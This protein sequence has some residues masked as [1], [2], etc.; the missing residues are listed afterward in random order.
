[1]L[2][3]VA[4]HSPHPEAEVRL[5]M[6]MLTLRA[7]RAG[8]G[9]VTGQDL[10]GWLQDDAERV[11]GRLVTGG[12]LRLPGTVAEVMASRPEDPVEVTVPTLLPEQPRPFTFGK[13]TRA[14][15]SGWAQKVVGDRKLRKRN[16]APPPGSWPCTPP[17]RRTPPRRPARTGQAGP[18]RDDLNSSCRQGGCRSGGE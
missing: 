4:A 13:T 7:A 2:D 8:T 9:N 10:T 6:L 1:M 12:W 15:I 5:A 3:Y 11:L 16:W 17:P 14:R 18:G